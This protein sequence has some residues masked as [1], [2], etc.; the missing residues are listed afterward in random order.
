MKE[1]GQLQKD[2]IAD[3]TI[4]DPKMVR[5][6]ST[7]AKGTLPTTGIPYVIVSGTIVV[8]DSKVLK[9]VNAGQ[10]IRFPIEDKPGFKSLDID[11]WKNEF[12]VAP[13][14]FGG[15]DIDHEH[16]H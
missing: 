15:L 5:D 10:P 12:L 3:I 13:V 14:G 9:G 11:E 2:M 6:N 7:Y 16:M 8:K 4:L 1:R